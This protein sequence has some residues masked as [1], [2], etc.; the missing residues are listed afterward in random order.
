METVG[1]DPKGLIKVNFLEKANPI[2][3]VREETITHMTTNPLN[4]FTDFTGQG[5]NGSLEAA[6][7]EQGPKDRRVLSV[8]Y[9][10]L[11]PQDLIERATGFKDSQK[12]K[13]SHMV[14]LYITK[15]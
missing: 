2:K 10:R 7:E 9:T 12:I 15:C 5:G 14:H 4:S 8:D 6:P 3:P 11:K 13:K 1:T